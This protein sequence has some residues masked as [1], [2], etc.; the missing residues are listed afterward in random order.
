VAVLTRRAGLHLGDQDIFVNVAGNIRLA[1][2]GVDLAICAAIA[3][4]FLDKPMPAD[5]AAVGEVGLL[6][7]VRKVVSLDKRIKEAKKL[8]YRVA[9]AESGKSVS[10]FLHYLST[11]I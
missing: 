11:G 1:D 10:A 7:E 2:R 8:G 5:I 6:G 4:S 9:S 3:S